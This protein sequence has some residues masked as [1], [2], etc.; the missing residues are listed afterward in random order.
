LL[1]SLAMGFC[2]RRRR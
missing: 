2:I 1:S